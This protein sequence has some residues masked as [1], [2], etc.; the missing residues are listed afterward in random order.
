MGM[1]VGPR[2][3]S[4][5]RR[6]ARR[7]LVD[8]AAGQ[9]HDGIVVP[10]F[11]VSYRR[12]DAGYAEALRVA[13]MARFGAHRVFKDVDSMAVGVSWKDQV[14]G[15]L[16]R[17]THVLALIGE[18][19]MDGVNAD[20]DVGEDADPVVFELEQAFRR[21]LPVVP[22]LVGDREM[23]LPDELPTPLRQYD[24]LSLNAARIRAQSPG[25]DIQALTEQ[26][27]EPDRRAPL[28]WTGPHRRSTR[29]RRVGILAGLAVLVVVGAVVLWRVTAADEEP[30]N[31]TGQRASG[32]GLGAPSEDG[33]PACAEPAASGW[34]S[35]P[36][37]DDPSGGVGDVGNALSFEVHRAAWRSLDPQTREVVLDTAMTND[38]QSPLQHGSWYY[39][40]LEVAQRRFDLSCI[41]VADQR[42]IDPGL[43]GDARI[44]FTVR[45]E[46]AGMMRLVVVG[47]D[48]VPAE[49]DTIEFGGPVP[50]DC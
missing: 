39:D 20:G 9:P 4:G 47:S 36:I 34:H 35:I 29:P 21:S 11:F 37:G 28:A 40:H 44:G 14:T 6:S 30:A 26:F 41:S 23:P 17:S 15:A 3:L 18:G 22:V 49:P 43:I 24:F 32:S 50:G 46:P 2:S 5:D 33:Y 45:C 13:L 38:S 12:E 7:E 10:T 31:D 16:D 48:T 1:C 19:W 42:F 25:P 8:G 27:A